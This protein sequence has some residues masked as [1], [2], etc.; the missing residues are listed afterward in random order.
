M[1]DRPS[2]AT[3]VDQPHAPGVP[4]TDKEQLL[5]KYGCSLSLAICFQEG[6]DRHTAEMKAKYKS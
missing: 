1:N 3:T 6:E 4:F 5:A 2:G